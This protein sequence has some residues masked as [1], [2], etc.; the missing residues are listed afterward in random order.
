MPSWSRFALDDLEQIASYIARD[1]PSAAQDVGRRISSAAEMLDRFP[2]A[3]RAGRVP[4]T[5]EHAVAGTRYVLVY[6][7]RSGIVRIMRVLHG[8]QSWPPTDG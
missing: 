2:G 5:R 4:S 7:V 1:N 3:G 6:R 8:A